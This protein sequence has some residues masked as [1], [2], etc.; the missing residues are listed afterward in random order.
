MWRVWLCFVLG[1]ARM[2]GKAVQGVEKWFVWEGVRGAVQP[3]RGWET[4][5]EDGEMGATSQK[6]NK[7]GTGRG[8]SRRSDAN[9]LLRCERLRRQG[10]MQCAGAACGFG[11][12][13]ERTAGVA[14]Q[15]AR[16]EARGA[17]STAWSVWRCAAEEA[18][19]GHHSGIRPRARGAAERARA[20][21]G[22]TSRGA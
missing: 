3:A 6:N 19:C 21:A 12:C 5:C 18:G 15:G 16:T 17:A 8:A 9:V 7:E 11:W 2:F 1:V 10:W 22:R 14:F 4:S 13:G 20:G